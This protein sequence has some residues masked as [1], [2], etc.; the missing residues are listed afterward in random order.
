M[1]L[2][3]CSYSLTWRGTRLMWS[4]S[5]EWDSWAHC[6]HIMDRPG[7]WQ[8]I[9]VNLSGLHERPGKT[10]PFSLQN[11]RHWQLRLLATCARRHDFG[12]F[13]IDLSQD[14]AVVSCVNIWTVCRR[15]LRYGILLIDGGGHHSTVSA[16]S[17]GNFASAVT[18]WCGCAGSGPEARAPR[19]SRKSY[20]LVTYIVI[21]HFNTD[22]V[23]I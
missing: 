6:Q 15:K 13:E 1:L 22:F 18:G 20:K 11:W 7:G 2:R 4:R 8:I 21:Y 14:I 5:H 19:N 17:V 10:R 12:S 23:H 9:G 16:G 3:H